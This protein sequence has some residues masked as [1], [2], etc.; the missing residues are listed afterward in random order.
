[1]VKAAFTI[2]LDSRIFINKGNKARLI[3]GIEIFMDII[4]VI[5]NIYVSER[6]MHSK[7]SSRFLIPDDLMKSFANWYRSSFSPSFMPKINMTHSNEQKL[8]F[9]FRNRSNYHGT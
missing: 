4:F 9:G 2:S 6:T 3:E 8:A 7:L 5:E 1:M